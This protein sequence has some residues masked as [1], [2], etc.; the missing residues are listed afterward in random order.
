MYFYEDSDNIHKSLLV[1][2][3]GALHEQ[4]WSLS[5]LFIVIKVFLTCLGVMLKLPLRIIVDDEMRCSLGERCTRRAV[6]T[7]P[8][9]QAITQHFHLP[10]VW[11][12]FSALP[13]P[14]NTRSDQQETQ[15][16]VRNREDIMAFLF[17]LSTTG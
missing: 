11:N 15:S 6:L 13:T 4:L 10:L 12:R 1:I 7:Q 5:S 8:R 16:Q 9:R 2:K 17:F 14:R 3:L